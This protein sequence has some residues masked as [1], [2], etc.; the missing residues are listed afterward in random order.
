MAERTRRYCDHPDAGCIRAWHVAAVRRGDS[1]EQLTAQ[2]AKEC[3]ARLHG[4]HVLLFNSGQIAEAG[5]VALAD[6]CRL[7]AITDQISTRMVGQICD[8][9]L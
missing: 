9:S 3:H 1:A 8:L 2:F 4:L 7:W 6:G 5:A